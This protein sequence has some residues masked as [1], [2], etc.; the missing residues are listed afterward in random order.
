MPSDIVSLELPQNIANDLD[1]EQLF[2]TVNQLIAAGTVHVIA[3][4]GT[5]IWLEETGLNALSHAKKLFV[6][7]GGDLHIFGLPTVANN[8]QV[9]QFPGWFPTKAEAV[10]AF[11]K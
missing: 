2:G 3:D 6:A 9:R 7:A 11:K 8:C 10:E 1:A 5:V 4:M